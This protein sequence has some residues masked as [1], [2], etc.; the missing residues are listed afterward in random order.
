MLNVELSFCLQVHWNF[1]RG[2][3]RGLTRD[4][5]KQIAESEY[6]PKL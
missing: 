4:D 5:P 3:T 1:T 2:L 6:D